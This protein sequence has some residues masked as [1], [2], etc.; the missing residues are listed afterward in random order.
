MAERRMAEIVCK[1]QRLCEV[2]IEAKRACK[3][4]G[5]LDDFQCVG[6]P[7]AVVIALVIDEDLR[8][9]GKPPEGGRMNDPVAV[10]PEGIARRACCFSVAPAAALR[11][12]GSINRPFTPRFDRHGNS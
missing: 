2:F 11:R 5:D 6:Q 10:P 9:V 3:R 8:L 7:R 12:I 4:P 1:C